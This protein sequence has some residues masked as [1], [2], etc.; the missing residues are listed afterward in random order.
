MKIKF[1]FHYIGIHHIG[2]FTLFS[3]SLTNIVLV[4]KKKKLPSLTEDGLSALLSFILVIVLR[5]CSNL[6]PVQSL[7]PLLWDS[8]RMW[9]PTHSFTINELHFKIKLSWAST[10]DVILLEISINFASE[11][12][13]TFLKWLLVLQDEILRLLYW[14]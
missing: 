4:K 11:N 13:N 2:I 3:G 14:Q 9:T 1:C 7:F 5:A 6:E 8:Y 10:T 12:Y